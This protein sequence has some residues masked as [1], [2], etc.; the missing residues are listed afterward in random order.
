MPKWSKYNRGKSKVKNNK[1]S[2]Y[3]LYKKGEKEFSM[4][5]HVY[6]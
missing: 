5:L 4:Y 2:F 6:K 3:F 1:G